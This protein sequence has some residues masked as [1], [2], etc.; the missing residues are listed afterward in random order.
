MEKI[1]QTEYQ[2]KG[3][4]DTREMSSKCDV[5]QKD[6]QRDHKTQTREKRIETTRRTK[7][8]G[9]LTSETRF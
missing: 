5:Q 3:S 9:I 8:R 4:K 6:I 1:G 7:Q 2:C